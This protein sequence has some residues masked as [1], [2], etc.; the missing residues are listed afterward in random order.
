[1]LYSERKDGRYGRDGNGM[2]HSHR[3]L[4]SNSRV[5]K[6][7]PEDARLQELNRAEFSTNSA[8]L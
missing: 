7:S 6:Q 3:Y 4:L 1:M 5:I 8:R 2:Y